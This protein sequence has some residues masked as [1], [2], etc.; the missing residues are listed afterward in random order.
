[1]NLRNDAGVLHYSF[2][3]ADIAY[4]TYTPII[5]GQEINYHDDLRISY[6]S[7]KQE[8]FFESEKTYL[9]PGNYYVTLLTDKKIF[10]ANLSSDTLSFHIIYP[11]GNELNALNELRD[12]YKIA[13]Q[14]ER[15]LR[16][17][18]YLYKYPESA[19]L[20]QAFAGYLFAIK[21]DTNETAL[22]NTIIADCKWFI[23]RRPDSPNMPSVIRNCYIMIE[24]YYSKSDEIEYLKK[25][26]QLYPD[27]RAGYDARVI[28]SEINK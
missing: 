24:K 20:D 16:Y 11:S 18:E 26:A 15:S 4:D 28:L 22:S 2:V 21:L 1:M 6:G 14:N 23:D 27:N 7:K 10:G 8:A 12:I 19:Y 3:I 25:V 9:P 13:S 17:R 5:A